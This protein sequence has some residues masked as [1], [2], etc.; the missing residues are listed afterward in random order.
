MMGLA[1]G[2]DYTLFILSRFREERATGRSVDDAI[3]RSAATASRAVLFSGVTVM[4]AL[5]GMLMIPFS[6]FVSMGVGMILVVLAAVVAALTL[7]PAVLSLLGY[8]VDRLRVPWRG[9]R[10]GPA[11]EGV[12]GRTARALMRRPIIT[13]VVGAGILVALLVPALDLQRG[14]TGAGDMPSYLSARQAYDMLA[15]DFSAGLTSPLLVALEGDQND[16][17]VQQAVARLGAAATADGRF[18][19]ID[20]ETSATGDLGVLRLVLTDAATDGGSDNQAVLD[21]RHTIIPE[22]VGEAPLKALVGGGPAQFA[23]MLAIVDLMTPIVFAVVLVLSFVL[24]LVVFR[25][26]VISATA[27]VMNLLSVGAAYGMLTLVFQ[28]GVGAELLGFQQTPRITTWVPLLLFCVLFGLSMD[29]QVFLLS[30]IREH[31]DRTGDTRESVV[32][33]ISSTSGLITGAALIMVAVF[34]GMASGDFVVFQQIGFGLAVAIALD[35]TVVH[36]LVFAGGT[37]VPTSGQGRARGAR[38]GRGKPR[39]RQGLAGPGGWHA[40]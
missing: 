4:L 36:D 23:D 21:L 20:Y 12:W 39:K 3:A 10:R 6:I 40:S 15:E 24:L 28:R 1:V 14:E 17:E 19:V 29:Y 2:I 34:G 22:A 11:V 26:V 8:R 5:I 9:A 27:V 37:L 35:V 7:L 30:R 33:G 31:Y 38:E 25:S 13:L 16:A 18:Q 32:F